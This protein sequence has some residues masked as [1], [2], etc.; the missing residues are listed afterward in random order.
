MLAEMFK[1]RK[2][3]VLL[4][5]K[6]PEPAPETPFIY[7]LERQKV[8]SEDWVQCFS[9]EKAGAVEVPGDCMP[10]EGDYR[11]RICSVSE[12]GRSPHV[13]FQGSAHLGESVLQ[14]R[15]GLSAVLSHVIPSP[16]F[17]SHRPVFLNAF[18][19]PARCHPPGSDGCTLSPSQCPQRA[20]WQVC[21]MCRSTTGKMLFSPSLSPPSPRAPGSLMERN[22]RARSRR[23][24]CSPEP[25]GTA[26]S[27]MARST[28]SPCKPS[29]TRI[30]ERWSAS[31]ARVCR[32]QLPSPS[33]VGAGGDLGGQDTSPADK[34]KQM[35]FP[36]LTSGP[37]E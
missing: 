37:G 27:T 21:R 19:L 13:V 25:C 16:S 8:G 4:T 9:V 24:R 1:G 15:P 14:S 10:S 22:S 33:K 32:I 26:W 35:L 2:N 5:W 34:M 28:G 7:R 36:L 11:F 23:A 29:S 17:C 3:V 20:W 31:A 12:H 6:P 30:A 18:Q